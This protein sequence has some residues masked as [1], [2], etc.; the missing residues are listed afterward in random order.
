THTHLSLLK[1]SAFILL[2]R[3][4][5]ESVGLGQTDIM[6]LLQN[7]NNVFGNNQAQNAATELRPQSP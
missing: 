4:S 7:L 1:K 6:A 2:I 3:Q 5:I